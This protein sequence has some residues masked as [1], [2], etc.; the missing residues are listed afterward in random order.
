[1]FN[2]VTGSD[3]PVGQQHITGVGQ[4][5]VNSAITSVP[6][7]RV[8]W[9]CDLC[10]AQKKTYAQVTYAD[11]SGI[12]GARV[13]FPRQLL[14]TLSQLDGLCY[15]VRA[16]DSDTVAHPLTTV[17]PR[18][19]VANLDEELLLNDLITVDHK[20]TSLKDEWQ[21]GSG[22]DRSEV[23][24]EQQLFE[25][26]LESLEQATPVRDMDFTSEEKH[27]LSG[28]GLLT[29]KPILVILNTGHNSEIWNKTTS[30]SYGRHSTGHVV[31]LRGRLEMEIAQ[32]GPE[33]AELFLHEY[34]LEQACRHRI[35]ELSFNT[36]GLHQFF[37]VIRDEVRAWTISVGAIALDAAGKIHSDMRNGFIRTEVIAFEDM[38][39][40]GSEASVKAAGKWRLEGR[41]YVVQ[42]GDILCV[43]FSPPAKQ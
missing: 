32:L 18:R 1:M 16:F 9:L 35:A 5:E 43:R 37:T 10:N 15:V 22:R 14:D 29:D 24:R 21:K 34:G 12:Q 27:L 19:D 40:H 23:E 17:D 33:D 4:V 6:D 26:L 30:D 13:R 41:E 2:A 38:K 8:D 11:I 39:S 36:L 25:R 28:Y 42:D 3:Q 20:L 31:A 7:L